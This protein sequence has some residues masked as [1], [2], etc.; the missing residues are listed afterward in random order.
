MPTR[1]TAPVGAPCWLDLMSSDVERSRSFYCDLFG[2][3]A[4]ESNPEFGGYFNFTKDGVLI[5][6]GMP[7]MEP[8]A[9]LPD[10]WSVY[11]ASDDAEATVAKATA[12]GA[13]VFVPPMVVGDYGTMAVMGDP[14][15]ATIGV[16]Q[17]NE[18]HG[19]GIFN[20]SDA[21]AWF[22]L[23]TKEYDASLAFYRDV[24]GWETDTVSDDPEFRYTTLGKGEDALAGVIDATSFP[25]TTGSQ[26]KVYFKVDDADATVAKAVSLGATLTQGPDDTPYGRLVVLTDPTAA[27]F[28]LL[29]PHKG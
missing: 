5:A 23:H 21:P 28:R 18:H 29:G 24:F 1:D 27:E 10:V 19:F 15:H 25:E 9:G 6:G 16:W 13:P 20:E 12:A 14:G 11:L 2:W 3:E 8:E 17:P 26:W 7:Q 4:E 22:E